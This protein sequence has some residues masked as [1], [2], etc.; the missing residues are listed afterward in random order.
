M[1]LSELTEAGGI[2]NRGTQ[3]HRVK[4]KYHRP[5]QQDDINY[6]DDPLESALDKTQDRAYH[7]YTPEEEQA[8][9]KA[10]Y[11][12]HTKKEAKKLARADEYPTENFHAKPDMTVKIYYWPNKEIGKPYT[13]FH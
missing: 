1:R 2:L 12:T 11:A 8:L 9:I 3:A 13:V 4:T 6:E 7:K 5:S 10:G